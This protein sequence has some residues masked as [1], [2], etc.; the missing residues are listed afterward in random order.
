ML[1]ALSCAKEPVTV[2]VEMEFTLQA[3]AITKA[4]GDG[5]A[6]N[7]LMVGVFDADGNVAMDDFRKETT[8]TDGQAHVRLTLMGTV[9]YKLVFWAQHDNT[10]LPA[11][12][13]SASLKA[14]S[15][16]LTPADAPNQADAFCAIYDVASA[17]TASG[18]EVTLTRPFGVIDVQDP[19]DYSSV[20]NVTVTVA[21]APTSYNA[22]AGTVSGSTTF[23]IY[24]GAPLT[25][26][27][28]AYAFLPATTSAIQ[29]NVTVNVDG[30]STLVENAPVRSNF[31]TNLIGKFK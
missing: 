12:W 7:K 2:P 3:D 24:N 29:Y 15:P 16:V 27:E 20:S 28:K 8:V 5:S 14:I 31:R 4:L 13:T 30:N 1:L 11:N 22:V 17:A 21:G 6:V 25:G 9:A 23:N 19:S 10:Y 18:I 26:T